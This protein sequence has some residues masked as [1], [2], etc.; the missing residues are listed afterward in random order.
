MSLLVL[1]AAFLLP[2]VDTSFVQT[3]SRK[4]AHGADQAKLVRDWERLRAMPLVRPEELAAKRFKSW[5]SLRDEA[6]VRKAT[7]D[8]ASEAGITEDMDRVWETFESRGGFIVADD[9]SYPY[10]YPDLAFLD[11][12]LT[13][14]IVA[15]H[16]DALLELANLLTLASAA[17][18]DKLD[19]DNP[20]A[21]AAMAAQS[22]IHRLVSQS[23]DCDYVL[24]EAWIVSLGRG[25]TLKTLK[26]LFEHAIDVCPADPTPRWLW[27]HRLI[28]RTTHPQV[29]GR[30]DAI[31]A[32][33]I[34][35]FKAWRHQDRRSGLAVLGESDALLVEAELMQHRRAMPFTAR[36]YA[37]QSLAGYQMVDDPPDVVRVGQ[38]RALRVLGREKSAVE[39]IDGTADSTRDVLPFRQWEGAIRESA[40]DFKSAS[41]AFGANAE[42]KLMPM[43]ADDGGWGPPLWLGSEGGLG[44]WVFD[45]TTGGGGAGELDWLGHIPDHRFP[46]E[47]TVPD[48]SALGEVRNQALAADFSGALQTFETSMP[49]DTPLRAPAFC[50]TELEKVGAA[51]Q[52]VYSSRVPGSPVVFDDL[53]QELLRYGGLLSEAERYLDAVVAS[54]PENSI[55][56]QRLGEVRFLRNDFAG[57]INA[58]KE[59]RRHPRD[60][61][62]HPQ[63]ELE[64]M[65][66]LA[67]EQS[68]DSQQARR[69]YTTASESVSSDETN[70]PNEDVVAAAESRLGAMLTDKNDYQEALPHLWHAAELSRGQ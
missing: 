50:E 7:L 68:G 65:L 16:A 12:A 55:A 69:W 53:A 25:V 29:S 23:Q 9:L 14:E 67:H 56:W 34:E 51:V 13:D 45:A 2:L 41:A 39:L 59:A 28:E 52:A 37:E 27:G 40:R 35:F 17:V 26:K 21:Q 66:G 64:L 47:L 54:R 62:V 44:T 36:S 31:L 18:E 70:A 49:P 32:A 30:R 58:F 15:E 24:T 63:G 33:P 43:F 19:F 8:L 61:T 1:L 38:A 10:G 3:G 20:L 6:K 46:P 11:R 60:A 4:H 22:I 57:A 48:C 5:E 42:A